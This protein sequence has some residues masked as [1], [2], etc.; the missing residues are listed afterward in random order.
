[1]NEEMVVTQERS[2]MFNTVMENLNSFSNIGWD[3]GQKSVMCIGAIP[4][5]LL[6]V[7]P[8]YQELRTHDQIKK[9][10]DNWD[11]R[12]LAP[13]TLVPH[14]EECR[15]AVVDGQARFRV[16]KEK[17]YPSLQAIVL[18]DAPEDLNERLVFEAEYFIGQ[19][20]ETEKVKPVEKHLARVIINDKPAV[21]VDKMLKKYS[22][23]VMK[24]KG[25]REASVLGSYIDTYDIAKTHGEKC[26]DFV[27][28]IITEAGWDRERN[29]YATFV[30]RSLRDIW[31]AH[32]L[33]REGIHQ[34]LSDTLRG[35]SPTLFRANALTSYPVRE[36]RIACVLHMEDIVCD[37]LGI[38]RKIYTSKKNKII[39]PTNGTF[40][41]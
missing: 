32:P 36:C 13:I 30:V 40:V 33:Y 15:F 20:T 31:V 12:K 10:R 17:G 38:E 25:Q 24:K 27:F 3:K 9:L 2:E 6:F 1:M 35:L 41:A 22:I 28:S 29:G 4:L 37:Q 7:D 18:M 11:V 39:L 8:R 21:I 34:M 19:D 23:Q 16:A 26:L 5:S 14:Y